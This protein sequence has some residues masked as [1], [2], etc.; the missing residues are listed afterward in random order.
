MSGPVH[1]LV[2]PLIGK[3]PVHMSRS[4]Q[5]S[6]PVH[7]YELSFI[8]SHTLLQVRTCFTVAHKFVG[9]TLEFGTT[10]S[11]EASESSACYINANHF[12][13]GVRVV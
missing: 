11:S 4:R 3:R 13:T 1:T 12:Y 6:G 2:V 8:G 10:E 9:L 7:N 5:M